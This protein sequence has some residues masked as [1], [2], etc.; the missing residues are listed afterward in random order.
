VLDELH[1]WRSWFAVEAKLSETRIDP[2]LVYFR[3]RLKLRWAYQVV[4]EASR[5][6]EQDGVRCLPA[7]QFLAALV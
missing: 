7:R 5:D 4:L 2:A 1:K 6:F 3:E